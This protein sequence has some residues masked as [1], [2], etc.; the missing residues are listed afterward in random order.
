MW[1]GGGGG[2]KSYSIRMVKDGDINPR[3]RCS[4]SIIKTVI[5][6]VY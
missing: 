5:V 1:W 3:D 2:L 4:R 6:A